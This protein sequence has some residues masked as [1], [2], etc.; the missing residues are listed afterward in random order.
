MSLP[1]T[2]GWINYVEPDPGE[3]RGAPLRGTPR[4]GSSGG[5]LIDGVGCLPHLA[6]GVEELD[7]VEHDLVLG[8]LGAVVGVPLAVLESAGGGDAAALVQVLADD[9]GQTVPGG[10]VDE[11]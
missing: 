1:R 8:A 4:A 2:P 3:G 11:H 7:L 6:L 5:Q 9:G 10:S